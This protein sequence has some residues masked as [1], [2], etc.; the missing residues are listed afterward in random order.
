MTQ[1]GYQLGQVVERQR[2]EEKTSASLKEKEVLLKEIH[3]RVKNNLQIIT[4]LLRL[5]S[6]GIQD[7]NVLDMFR[8]SQSRVRSMA[9]VHEYLYKSPDLA[10]VKFSDYVQNIVSGLFRSYGVQPDMVGSPSGY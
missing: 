7:A 4:S 9:L 1:V 3:H 10:S 6:E 2:I 8:E 5:Q